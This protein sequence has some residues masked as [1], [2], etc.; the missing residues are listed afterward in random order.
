MEIRRKIKILICLCITCALLICIDSY[1]RES[2][3]PYKETYSE[4]YKVALLDTKTEKHSAYIEVYE[5]SHPELGDYYRIKSF[6]S[7]AGNNSWYGTF[8]VFKEDEIEYDEPLIVEEEDS[9]KVILKRKGL[10]DLVYVI[11][12]DRLGGDV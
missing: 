8:R 9:C 2:D 4:E 1:Y 11:P 6:A 12:Y 5:Y 10:D 3:T 7:L